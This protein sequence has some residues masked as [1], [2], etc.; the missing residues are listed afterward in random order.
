MKA[1]RP[2]PR[3][4]RRAWLLA[5]GTT[6]A[7]LALVIGGMWRDVVRPSTPAPEWKEDAFVLSGEFRADGSCTVLLDSQPLAGADTTRTEYE[8]GGITGM[9][10]DGFDVHQAEC[11]AVRPLDPDSAWDSGH[12]LAWTAQPEGRVLAPGRYRVV[13]DG[14]LE[15]GDS[16]AFE[17]TLSHPRFEADRSY[18]AGY[19]GYVRIIRADTMRVVGSF[20]VVARRKRMTPFS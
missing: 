7:F 17:A 16:T 5:G 14:A 13:E 19:Q 15:S 8:R 11:G 20:R 2:D 12:F 9:T 10:P 1:P 4:E 6:A 3:T 18:L